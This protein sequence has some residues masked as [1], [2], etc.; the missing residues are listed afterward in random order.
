MKDEYKA[1]TVIVCQCVLAL[2]VTKKV[3]EDLA[4]AQGYKDYI[5]IPTTKR[6][7]EE[8]VN[9]DLHV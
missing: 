3:A 9:E 5:V 4:K 6:H 1:H 7:L 8:F 2:G